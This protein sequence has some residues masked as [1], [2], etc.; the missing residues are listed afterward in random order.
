MK[1]LLSRKIIL[2]KIKLIENSKIYKIL[3]TDYNSISIYGLLLK[4]TDITI[5]YEN[6]K[7]TIYIKPESILYKIDNY[8][9]NK[10]D[11][12]T[13]I[14]DD[15][16]FIVHDDQYIKKYYENNKTEIFINIKYI[17]K[18]KKNIPVLNIIDG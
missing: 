12:Y 8:L 14:I 16:K 6:N 1:Y 10:I 15:N 13:K 18:T 9:N 7:F 11:N 4:L 5:K 17:L 3:Y 2:S